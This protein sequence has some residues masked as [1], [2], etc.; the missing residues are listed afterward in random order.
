MIYLNQGGRLTNLCPQM[1]LAVVMVDQAYESF[2]PET[3]VTSVNDGT[4]GPTSLH[5]KGQA[6]DFRLHNVYKPTRPA[7]VE[8]IKRRLNHGE[9][10]F[11]VYWEAIGTENEHLHLE[12]DPK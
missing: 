12:Y 7:L 11:E 10:Q 2:V 3:W 8:H 1:A 5:P 4:H 9:G 6:V